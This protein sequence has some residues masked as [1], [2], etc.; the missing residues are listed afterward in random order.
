M[1]VTDRL[2]GVQADLL[3]VH[4]DFPVFERLGKPV[5]AG[6]TK[7]RASR[8]TTGAFEELKQRVPVR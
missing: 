4:V 3:N 8:S 7:T 6:R 1:A 2:A 5:A